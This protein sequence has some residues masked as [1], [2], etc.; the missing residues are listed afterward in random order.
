MGCL[1]VW[2]SQYSRRGGGAQRRFWL[3]RHVSCGLRAHVPPAAAR[4]TPQVGGS[5]YEVCVN[6]PV[7][8]TTRLWEWRGG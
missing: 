6:A 5:E 8:E 3:S 4:V 1:A 7:T 2:A